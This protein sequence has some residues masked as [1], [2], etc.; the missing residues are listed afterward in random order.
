MLIH[1]TP[2]GNNLLKP[3]LD[4]QNAHS[5][6]QCLPRKRVIEIQDNPILLKLVHADYHTVAVT[7]RD[8]QLSTLVARVLRN[9]IWRHIAVSIRINFAVALFRRECHFLDDAYRQP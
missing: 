5:E 6:V 8:N 7:I 1:C 4:V 9:D 3:L 2:G